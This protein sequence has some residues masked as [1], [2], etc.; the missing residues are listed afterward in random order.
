[1]ARM[2]RRPPDQRPERQP[3]RGDSVADELRDRILSGEYADGEELPKLPQLFEEFGV[4]MPSVREAMRIL[5]T[6]G[7]ITMRRGNKGGAVAHRPG[8]RQAAYM[9][10]LVLQSTQ[11]PVADLALA[12]RE[13]DPLCAAMCASR[14]D[15]ARQVIPHLRRRHRAAKAALDDFPAFVEAMRGFHEEM[16]QR[17]GNQTIILLLGMLESIWYAHESDWAE[18]AGASGELPGMDLRLRS[19]A[20]HEELIEVIASGDAVRAM[21][22]AHAHQE[23]TQPNAVL[24]AATASKMRVSAKVVRADERESGSPRSL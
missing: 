8:P 21:E 14:R 18:K 1:M 7:L 15:R 2:P 12:V 13:V 9:F 10:G 4:S 19:L 16:V 24:R 22:L 23:F 6:E 17:C 5:E 11:V 3:R 20:D